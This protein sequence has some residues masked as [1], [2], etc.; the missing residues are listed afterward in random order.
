M[1]RICTFA[2]LTRA[3]THARINVAAVV[4]PGGGSPWA[5]AAIDHLARPGTVGPGA[6][7]ASRSR[8]GRASCAFTDTSCAEPTGTVGARMHHDVVTDAVPAPTTVRDRL[9]AAGISAERIEQ[10]MTAGLVR[11][12]GQLVTDLDTSAP[13]G[14]RVVIWTE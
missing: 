2:P 3:L 4:R 9:T 1:K 8:V 10:H 12:D 13:A 11:V 14:T 7:R 5:Q 6:A